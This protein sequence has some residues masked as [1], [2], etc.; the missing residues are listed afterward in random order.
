MKTHK[1]LLAALLAVGGVAFAQTPAAAPAAPAA[2][3]AVT[4]AVPAKAAAH[5]AMHHKAARRHEEHMAAAHEM[6]MSEAG[7]MKAREERMDAAYA[8]FKNGV[9]EQAPP[10]HHEAMKHHPRKGG[11]HHPMK[12]HEDKKAEGS[13]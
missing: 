11:M 4:P 9:P 1:L 2:T 6:P 12:M 7:E 5:K 13:K 3:P 10:M 8:N